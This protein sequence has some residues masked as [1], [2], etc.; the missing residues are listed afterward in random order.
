MNSKTYY[1]AKHRAHA[2]RFIIALAM[3]SNCI[4]WALV[5]GFYTAMTLA[6]WLCIGGVFFL[7]VSVVEYRACNHYHARYRRSVPNHQN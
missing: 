5:A 3:L 6:L 1:Y 4:V 7:F 2:L